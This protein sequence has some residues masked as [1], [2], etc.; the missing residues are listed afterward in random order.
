VILELLEYLTTDCPPYARRLGYLKEAIAIKARY[1]RHCEAWG[2]HL[3]RS[4][5]V[6]NAAMQ[7]CPRRRTVLVIGSGLLLDIPLGALAA[8]FERV[9]LVDVVHLRAARRIAARHANVSLATADVTGLADGL[10]ARLRDG[11]RGAP[12]PAPTLFHDDGGID[13]V[14]SANVLAQLPVMPAAALRR[15]GADD[16]AVGAFC[17]AVVRAHLAYLAGFAGRVCLISETERETYT[18]DGDTWRTDDALYGL[19]LP[20]GG[21]R[22][23][24]E[25]APVGE[26]SRRYGIRNHVAGFDVFPGK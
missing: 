25:L 1:R 14:V 8:G 2:P 23:S 7:A 18:P 22:W 15:A 17:A 6:V 4:R 11:W 10:A 5:A 16:I 19:S 21:A 12:V 9:L 3:A 13:L 24:W 26:V 20:E